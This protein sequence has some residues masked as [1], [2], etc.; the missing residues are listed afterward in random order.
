LYIFVPAGAQATA[1]MR[2]AHDLDL[3]GAGVTLISTED[4]DPD[5]E[6]PN[7]GDLGLGLVT[8]GI[9]SA[10]AD[11]PANK[12]FVEAY[13]KEYGT[14]LRPDFETADAWVGMK[15]IF[16]MIKETHGKFT[17]QQAM[18]YFEH[19]KQQTSPKGPWFIDPKTRQIV[20]HVYMRKIEKKDGKL[21]DVETEDLGLIDANGQP[22]KAK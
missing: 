2:A 17:G 12:E 1:V 6:I 19:Y 15:M 5:E 22:W 8:S 7:M 10:D 13:Y 3:K 21:V 11:R 14:K 18:T 4:L 9:Y 16:D 20:Q